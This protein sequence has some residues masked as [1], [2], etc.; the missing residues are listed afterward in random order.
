[1]AIGFNKYDTIADANKEFNIDIALNENWDKIDA[2]IAEIESAIGGLGSG[3]APNNVSNAKIRAGNGKVTITWN[4]PGDTI[5]DG[6]LLSTWKGTKL[7]QKAGSPPSNVKDG[8]VLLDNQTKNA[9]AV[10]GFVVNGLTNGTTYY[11]QL[12]PYSDKNAV[13]E[14][15]ANRLSASPTHFR[16]MTVVIDLTNSNPETCITYADDA[17]EMTA[18]AIEWDDF[19]GH[20]PVL[21]KNGA[22]VGELN[23]NDF[24]KFKDG[25]TADITSGNAGDVMVA[26]PKRGLMINTVGT[27][28]T[29][30]MTDEPDKE[31]FEYFAHSR[32]S[33]K[34][35][36]FYLGAYKGF[37]DGANKLRSL[38][39]QV[40]DRVYNNG[41]EART[42]AQANGG[43]YEQFCFYQLTFIQAMYL[44]K[45]KHLNSQ[46]AVGQGYSS[47]N[48][49]Y[50]TTGGTDLKGMD[51]GETTGKLQMKL[52]G[53]EDFYGN[54]HEII[55][56]VRTDLVE[57]NDGGT[58]NT[59]GRIR[60]ATT[61]FNDAGTG[62]TDQGT[63]DVT[64][65]ISG[66]LS[67][68]QGTTAKGFLAKEANGSA[69]TYFCD[70]ATLYA[71]QLCI[72]SNG[73]NSGSDV[74]VFRLTASAVA[75][76]GSRLMYL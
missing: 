64:E 31:G 36:K 68:P 2:K 39:G 33:S 23:K 15:A 48:T 6:Q 43:G 27:T 65:S 70:G 22:E 71:N 24:T 74:G 35:E 40:F 11:F 37:T 58:T 17:V 30:K 10:N 59:F 4:D 14:N 60:T 26:F 28:L 16:T 34:K 49:S 19:F 63:F 1:M 45:Y 54:H 61:G 67:K 29:V 42:K 52:F 7:V 5:V 46:V 32:G 18:G 72:F 47:G 69:T 73:Y 62:Y 55:D 20:Y 8:T 12:F 13:N 41:D 3:I 56:G 66:Y 38:S 44:L 21:F 57:I 9:Y 50:A 25:S 53:I 75:Q 51:F 76:A